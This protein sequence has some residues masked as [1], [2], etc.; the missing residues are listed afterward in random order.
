MHEDQLLRRIADR[1]RALAGRGGVE[2]GPGDDCAMLRVGAGGQL[3]ATVDHL[4]EFRH[5]EPGT[6]LDLVA[7]KAVARSVSDV[8]AMAGTPRWALATGA[9]PADWPQQRAEELFDAMHRWAEGF[10]CPLVGGDIASLPTGAPLVLTVTVLGE[11]HP[12]RGPVRRGGARPGQGVYLTGAVGGSLHSGRHLTF[13]PRVPEARWL[14]DE[15]GARL[16]A[17]IDVSDGLG[18]DAGRLARAG[19]VAIELNERAV[20][21][22]PDAGPTFLADGEDYELL[23]AAEGPV[24]DLCPATGTPITRI[25]T[26]AAGS[27]CVVVAADGRRLPADESGWDHGGGGIGANN[28]E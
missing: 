7:R 21:R 13:Q 4:I 24:P 27:G 6:P 12:S 16:A 18:R 22:H 9:I 11:P 23:F 25:G 15:L 14:A 17:M 8:A 1:T 2:I 10:G 5:F 3:L 26:V 20:P 28:P 19:G